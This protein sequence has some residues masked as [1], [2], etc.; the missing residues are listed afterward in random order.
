VSTPKHPA[1]ALPVGQT[2]DRGFALLRRHPRALL[3]PQ[4]VLNLVPLVAALVLA[5]VGSVLLGDVATTKQT[6]RE[7]TFTG[8]STL[9]VRDVADYTAGQE[10]LLVVLAVLGGLVFVFCAL[11]AW[12]SVVRGADRALEGEP[13]LPLRA[14]VREALAAAPRLFALAV[15]FVAGALVLLAVLAAVV[16]GG[17]ALAGT[18][19]LLA[20]AVAG[21]VA[22]ALAVRVLLWPFVHLA[23]GRGLGA[24]REAWELTRGRFWPLLGVALVAL[25]AV[26]AASFVLGLLVQLVVSDLLSLNATVGTA[27]AIPA[28]LLIVAVNLVLTAG[29]LAPT[30]VAYRTLTGRATPELP[31][32]GL[33]A[34]PYDRPG[35]PARPAAHRRDATEP[36][37]DA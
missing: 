4:L 2:V 19:A 18:L 20:A 27:A 33:G 24:F 10:V 13:A 29:Y 14:A 37:L 31:A 23:E 30:V 16:V 5:L 15:V 35:T 25:V 8:D 28:V 11:A 32:R 36:P 21:L 9:V 26:A 12:A 34:G 3:V 1:P 6:V 22:V 7:S 17:A